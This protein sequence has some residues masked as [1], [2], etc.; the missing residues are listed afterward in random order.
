MLGALECP[1][2]P[3][4]HPHPVTFTLPCS[5]LPSA[6]IWSQVLPAQ[7]ILWSCDRW[8]IKFIWNYF[9]SDLLSLEILNLQ[10]SWLTPLT[11]FA[12]PGLN[13]TLSLAA[14]V[15]PGKSCYPCLCAG[16]RLWNHHLPLPVSHLN[17]DAPSLFSSLYLICIIDFYFNRQKSSKYE[18][19]TSILGVNRLVFLWV[20]CSP[21]P[22][23]SMESLMLCG[24]NITVKSAG[25]KCLYIKKHLG[26][27]RDKH[28]P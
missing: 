24:W 5:L 26:F 2:V 17:L 8:Q 27:T 23:R 13:I 11:V 14:L 1:R 6:P 21:W 25:F 9:K 3:E 18:N 7:I 12:W 20:M 4:E 16:D 10:E 19:Q 15:I 22:F 28:F